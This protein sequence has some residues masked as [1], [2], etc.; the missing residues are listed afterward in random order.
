MA[1]CNQLT[2]TPLPFKELVHMTQHVQ[3]HVC[4]QIVTRRRMQCNRHTTSLC[5]VPLRVHACSNSL[6][7]HFPRLRPAAVSDHASPSSPSV[8]LSVCVHSCSVR[9]PRNFISS[10]SVWRPVAC[11]YMKLRS[12]HLHLPRGHTQTQTHS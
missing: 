1:K 7:K 10:E 9:K 12:K 3:T 4:N 11:V 2:V 5:P 8:C 6:S